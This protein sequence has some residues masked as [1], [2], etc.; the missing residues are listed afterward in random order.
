MDTEDHREDTTE[1]ALG[2]L[3]CG[4]KD[5]FE[6]DPLTASQL[7]AVV[8]ASTLADSAVPSIGPWHQNILEESGL[9][10]S[11]G[12][13]AWEEELEV[14]PC[15]LSLTEGQDVI[16]SKCPIILTTTQ[17][18]KTWTARWRWLSRDL[19][20]LSQLTMSGDLT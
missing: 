13:Q 6:D 12:S 7:V 9:V 4:D 17:L 15:L 8:K 2:S 14:D 16:V 11:Q 5:I 20:I 18:T 10:E 19:A 1:D 3:G